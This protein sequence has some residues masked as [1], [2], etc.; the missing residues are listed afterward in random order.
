MTEPPARVTTIAPEASFLDALAAG[1]LARWGASP[2]ELSQ[3]LVFLPTRR[4]CRGL[5]DA[6]LRASDGRPLLLPRMLPLGDLDEDELLLAGDA[7]PGE[8]LIEELPPA[9]SPLRRQLLL[10][11]LIHGWTQSTIVGRAATGPR[12]DQAV[13]LAAELAR[14]LDQVETE[15]LDFDGL[16][17]LV[18]EEYAAHWQTTL[19]FLRILTDGWP[20]V[21]AQQGVIGPAERR[22]R[23]LLAQ[24]KAWAS[25]APADPVIVA[26]STG[27]VPAVAE[28]IATVARLPSGEVVLPGVDRA[29]DEAVWAAI[30]E[31]PSH[32]QHGLARLLARLELT[33]ED[34]EDWPWPPDSTAVPADSARSAFVGWA[35]RP[36]GTTADWRD[37]AKAL[38]PDKA[39]RALDGVCRIDCATPNEEAGVIALLMRE[40]LETPHETAALVTP[41]RSLARRVAAELGRWHIEA[42]D[43][44]GVPLAETPCGSFL[45]LTAQ[46]AAGALAP[47]DLL[48]ALKHPFAAGGLAVP[49]FRR[50]ARLL[51]TEVLRGPR[52]APGFDGL[53]QAVKISKARKE[54]APWVAGL[55]KMAAPF[56]KA[57]EAKR[58]NPAKVVAKHLAF[59]EALAASDEAMGGERLWVEE[60][61]DV[62]NRFM[63]ELY[64]AAAH[65]PALGGERYPALLTALMASQVVRPR[66]GRH[67][68]LA[69][70]GPLEARLQHFDLVIL[71]G[72]N[73]GTWP[74]QVDPGPWL[75]RP[76]QADFGLSLPERRIGLSAH[77]FAQAF[78]APRVVL[79]R[80]G[81]VEG[82]PTVP[83]R[84]LLRIDALLA[85]LNCPEAL[86]GDRGRSP[87]W[88]AALDRP[89]RVLPA[90]APAPRPPL[91]ARPR[92]LSVT[93]IETWM[94]DPY[95]LYARH[96]LNLK[97]LDPLDADPGAAERGTL[98][99]QALEAYI[100]AYPE[101]PPDDPLA[102]LIG[103]GRKVFEPLRAR[104]GL[105]AF[106]WPRF[107]RVAEWFAVVDLDLRRAG[108]KAWP[109]AHGE[110]TLD[111]PAGAFILTAKA[112][113]ID[114]LG[115]GRLVIVD[116]KTG[117]P[118]KPKDV[119]QGFA[120]QLPLEAVIAQDGGFDGVPSGAVAEL[121]YWRLSG[122]QPAG[123][124]APAK[125]DPAVLAE[126]ARAGLGRLIACFDDPATGYSSVPR[127]LRA[128]R[129]NDYAHLARLKEWSLGGGGTEPLA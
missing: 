30:A 86:A 120:P 83:S 10:A 5:G 69:I 66:Y 23:L 2:L 84:W 98:V 41:D 50:R 36:A 7:M 101:A 60:A 104:P 14:F 3:A 54:L 119:E 118:P 67:P 89:E 18:G 81:R 109:E 100:R 27:S 16:A 121:Q 62:A 114:R 74:A 115:D 76:M 42:D 29:S 63:G 102:A 17:G 73:E 39:A 127:P 61:G 8:G 107:L 65:G 25:V 34:I 9:I 90:P 116:Y 125:E 58:P 22:R 43:S 48:A 110:L 53:K 12:E 56:A 72:L 6:F 49:E 97:P 1:L 57:L 52:P 87:A 11:R 99:H 24:A 94:R 68:R 96:V 103:E 85:A 46:M 123:E 20:Q 78:A 4:A 31:D 28:L 79:T 35:L 91:E 93:Q 55:A 128:P 77:D 95:A 37:A 117:Q 129:F 47:V 19:N 112:D 40:A 21:Q 71:G 70:L 108:R 45:R 33:R 92:R 15:G 111:G 59:A 106:W 13:R 124:I 88:A 32:A 44:A 38:P 75:S 113:R 82:T 26:G 122:G 51:E 80:A 105:W 64:D 126:T